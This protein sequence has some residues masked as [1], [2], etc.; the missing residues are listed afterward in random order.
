MMPKLVALSGP[1]KGESYVLLDRPLS[2][3]RA[4]GSSVAIPDPS[5]SRRHCQIRQEGDRYELR[6]LK[7]RNGTFVNAVPVIRRLLEH[8]DLVSIGDSLFVVLFEDQAPEQP[9]VIFDDDTLTSWSTVQMGMDDGYHAQSRKLESAAPGSRFAH[10]LCSLVE[11]GQEIGGIHDVEHQ[12]Q[13]VLQYLLEW[14]PAER[15]AVLLGLIPEDIRLV[16][17][18]T[19][20]A[21]PVRHVKISRTLLDRVAETN[22]AILSRRKGDH[23]GLYDSPSLDS[24]ELA[25]FLCVPLLLQDRTLGILYADTSDP[26]EPFSDDDLGLMIAVARIAAGPLA[27]ALRLDQSEVENRRLREAARLE[28]NMIGESVAMRRVY[29]FIRKVAP[30]ESTVLIRGE[31]GTGKELV[32]HAIHA[33]SP[34]AAHPFVAI[35]CAALTETLLESE[36]FGH[37]KGAFTGAVAQKKGRLE[38]AHGGTVF[39][40]EIGELAPPLQA[41]LLRVLQTHEVERVGGN[42]AMPVDFRMVAATNRN[43]EEAIKTGGFRSDLYYRLN[44]VSVTLPPL[45]ERRTDIPLL[46]SYFVN[47]YGAAT[48]KRVAGISEQAR[49]C[50]EVYDWPGNVR[51]LENAIEHAIVLGSGQ[52]LDVDDLPEAVLETR[53]P[54]A[55]PLARYHQALLEFKKQLIIQAVELASGNYTKAAEALGIHPN[56]LHRIVRNMKLRH[57]LRGSE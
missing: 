35:N 10:Q 4:Q 26:G 52:T 13:R 8:G 46:A 28:H 40:D 5:V 9:G 56:H 38:M 42:R 51:E 33:N 18:R 12:A 3:G 23:A 24:L 50:L 53:L 22:M 37:E 6:D 20:Q 57:R 16:A 36:L 29:E 54:G 44:V 1:L 47:R 49:T 48:K 15:G 27:G 2:I 11:F 7:S 34:R 25:S 41:K 19:R 14:V 31:S 32:A 39:L 17:A 21:G 43:L 30:A 55:I 45:R